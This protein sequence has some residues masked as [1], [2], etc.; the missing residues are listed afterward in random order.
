VIELPVS[1][2]LS[3]CDWLVELISHSLVCLGLSLLGLL[4]VSLAYLGRCHVVSMLD[5]YLV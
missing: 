4:I 3:C 2:C 1:C 5:A